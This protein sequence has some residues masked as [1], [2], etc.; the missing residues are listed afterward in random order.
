MRRVALTSA[1]ARKLAIFPPPVPLPDIVF[2]LIWHRR[3]DAHPAQKWFR[4]LIASI[5]ADL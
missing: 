1:A 2:D 5:A 4:D 3:A